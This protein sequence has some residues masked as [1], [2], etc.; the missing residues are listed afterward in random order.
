M[1]GGKVHASSGCCELAELLQTI[2]QGSDGRQ[3]THPSLKTGMAS[4]IEREIK[5]AGYDYV[6]PGRTITGILKSVTSEHTGNNIFFSCAVSQ[7][8]PRVS[9]N[10]KVFIV[11]YVI[12]F[13]FTQA[14]MQLLV[15]GRAVSSD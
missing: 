4:E 5:T 15:R 13:G 10:L 11:V 6:K 8:D 12:P 2:I 9:T 14:F 7:T 3:G 1:E